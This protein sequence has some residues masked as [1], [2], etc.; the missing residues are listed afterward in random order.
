[1]WV[2]AGLVAFYILLVGLFGFVRTEAGTADNKV[3]MYC[4]LDGEEYYYE[5][6]FD[7]N[8]R[9]GSAGGDSWVASH[10]MTEQYSDANVLMAQVEDYFTERGGSVEF[11]G[12]V[13]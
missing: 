1:M 9:I 5:V 7:E 12:D 8:F 11:V 4:Y 6:L 3:E 10:V 13:P 2:L